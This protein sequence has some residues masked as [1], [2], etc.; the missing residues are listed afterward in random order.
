MFCRRHWFGLSN[1]ELRSM[2]RIHVWKRFPRARKSET[3]FDGSIVR[4]ALDMYR[5]RNTC[6]L[7]IFGFSDRRSSSNTSIRTSRNHLIVHVNLPRYID[8]EADPI[9]VL[10]EP[11][12]LAGV[13]QLGDL[14]LP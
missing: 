6:S 4:L 8:G 9:V 3:L 10:L 14:I 12:L 2:A 13:Q 11:H 5:G 7:S 1:F